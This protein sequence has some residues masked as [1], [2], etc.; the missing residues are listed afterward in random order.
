[1]NY[2][3]KKLHEQYDA[4]G[5]PVLFEC[6][7]CGYRSQSLGA[8]H[9]HIEQHRGYTRLNMQLPFTKTSPAKA[10]RLMDFTR[11]L[12]VDDTT[13]ITLDEVDGL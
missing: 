6:R 1:M 3:E 8:L 11:V 13:E 12:R 2:I 9:G 7:E 10:D 4:A 5:K